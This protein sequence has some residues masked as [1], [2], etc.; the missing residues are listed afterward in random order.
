M[1]G[2]VPSVIALNVGLSRKALRGI[3]G[4]VTID[5]DNNDDEV[6]VVL[7]FVFSQCD[8]NYSTWATVLGISKAPG[9]C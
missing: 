1:H 6:V 4:C 9:S 3:V 8:R 2:R 5:D 7:C